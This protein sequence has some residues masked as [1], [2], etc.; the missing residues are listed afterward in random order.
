MGREY[1]GILDRLE[2][3]EA[4]VFLRGSAADVLFECAR[5]GQCC[6]G[7]AYTTVDDQDI[8]RI[9]AGMGLEPE[10]VNRT[11]T[12]SDPEDRPGMRMIKNVGPENSCTF[13]DG[14]NKGC[15]I[16]ELRPAICRTHPMMN[17]R[18]GYRLTLYNHCLGASNLINILRRELEN[19]CANRYHE[20]LKSKQKV[21]KRL[22]IKLLIHILQRQGSKEKS[23]VVAQ[24]S[25]IK[26]PLDMNDLRKASLAYLL[27]SIDAKELD[28]Y[29]YEGI[30]RQ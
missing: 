17:A 4:E 18:Q 7:G 19:L 1:D 3:K 13:Y 30:Q 6:L 25:G 9:A 23:E 8:N 15:T 11:F 26:L 29:K 12:T 21:L 14:E 5:C 28:G 22:K 10:N 16:Y 27:L 20:R 2:S 24:L